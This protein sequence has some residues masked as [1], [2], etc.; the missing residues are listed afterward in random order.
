[1]SSTAFQ[2]VKIFSG[3]LL[4]PFFIVVLAILWPMPQ[5]VPPARHDTVFIKSINV[6]DVLSGNILKD[7]DVH[8]KDNIIV[9]IDT[10]GVLEPSSNSLIIDGK[11]K[12]LMRGLWDMHTHSVKYSESL[13]HPLYIANG[14]TGIR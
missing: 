8:L 3:I 11:N 5:L 1:M 7:R 2:I 12:F 13:H 6:I 9:A 4:F 10:S 14:V